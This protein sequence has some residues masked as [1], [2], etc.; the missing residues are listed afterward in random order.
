MLVFYKTIMKGGSSCQLKIS[1][2]FFFAT[3]LVFC[4]GALPGTNRV[5][6]SF[7]V[8]EFMLLFIPLCRNYA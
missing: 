5:L 6:F 1:R 4:N 2:N 3:M 8:A 7:R